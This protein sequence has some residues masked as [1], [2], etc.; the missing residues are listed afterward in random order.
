MRTFLLLAL[1]LIFFVF[2]V[3]PDYTYQLDPLIAQCDEKYGSC[4]WE[5][6]PVLTDPL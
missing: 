2:I 1:F 4:C 6:C 5:F 3:T